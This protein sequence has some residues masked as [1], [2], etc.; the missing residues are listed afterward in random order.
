M[1][2]RRGDTG[3]MTNE[4]MIVSENEVTPVIENEAEQKLENKPKKRKFYVVP[5][6]AAIHLY[7]PVKVLNDEQAEVIW[8]GQAMVFPIAESQREKIKTIPPEEGKI[9]FV[10]LWFRTAE[11]VATDLMLGSVL[12]AKEEKVQALTEQK[13][14]DFQIG[15]RIEAVDREE[16]KVTLKIEPNRKGH[17]TEAFSVEVWMALD[18]MDKLQRVGRTMQFQG[19]YRP[20]SGRLVV[21]KVLPQLIGERPERPRGKPW[22]K[23][24]KKVPAEAETEQNPDASAQPT[25]A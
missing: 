1:K 16:G 19:E 15:G 3:A 21:K 18:L 25:E 7:S 9:Y 17:L 2:C 5:F 23:K 22:K 8:N 4:P 12:P 20:G 13:F 14:L 10:Q 11:G 24:Q 6:H